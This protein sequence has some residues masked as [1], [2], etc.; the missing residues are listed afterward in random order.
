M[1]DEISETL[2]EKGEAAIFSSS[3]PRTRLSP[4]RLEV[5]KKRL[6]DLIDEFIAEKP[7]PHGQVYGLFTTLFLAPQ[8]LQGEQS[9]ASSRPPVSDGGIS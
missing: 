9:S 5:Y 3:F 6:D 8:Y 4:E 7:D 1:Y 2:A